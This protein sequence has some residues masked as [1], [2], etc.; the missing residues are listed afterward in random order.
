MIDE[1]QYKLFQRLK[2]INDFTERQ[3]I[4]VSKLFSKSSHLWDDY[5]ENFHSDL[6]EIQKDISR[7]KKMLPAMVSS[8]EQMLTS[9]VVI[10][11]FECLCGLL[12]LLSSKKKEEY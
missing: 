12:T 10:G 6:K 9:G 3:M 4:S 8:Q 11:R 5:R 7:I 2:E 1:Y